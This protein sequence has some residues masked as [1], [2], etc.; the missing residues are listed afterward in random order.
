MIPYKVVIAALTVDLCSKTMGIT[1]RLATS[2]ASH[3]NR[4][5]SKNVAFRSSPEPARRGQ[6]T[7]VTVGFEGPI[8]AMAK[9]MD[10]T[11]R[12]A[13]VIEVEDL[14]ADSGVFEEIVAPWTSP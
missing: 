10:Y 3:H 8:G 12:C 14:L 9:R 5:A 4:E 7:P 2:I 11:L 6:V 1:S 13:F